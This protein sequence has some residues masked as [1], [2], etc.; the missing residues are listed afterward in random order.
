[1]AAWKASLR[2]SRAVGAAV[3]RDQRPATG[4]ELVGEAVGD[5]GGLGARV[6]PATRGQD[7]CRAAGR[8][9]A[10]DA[11]DDGEDEDDPAVPVDEGSPAAEHRGLRFLVV[12]VVG[13]ARGVCGS[14]GQ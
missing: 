3:D 8:R 7:R 4:A 2:A 1:M 13:L 5:G 12:E 11:D 6:E 14:V 9:R 10:D